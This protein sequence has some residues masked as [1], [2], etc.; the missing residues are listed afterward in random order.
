M[1]HLLRMKF[2]AQMRSE[3]NKYQKS[4][5]PLSYNIVDYFFY[6]MRRKKIIIRVSNFVL[7]RK[8][9]IRFGF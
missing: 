8:R 1:T 7:M 3:S 9:K 2:L 5:G 6:D 4:C